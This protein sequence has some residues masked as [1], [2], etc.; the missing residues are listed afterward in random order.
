KI[1]NNMSHKAGE[2]ADLTLSAELIN[3]LLPK[4]KFYYRFNGSLTTPPCS[5]GVRW[6]VLQNYSTISSTQTKE[7]LDIFHHENSRPVQSIN[8]RKVM[9]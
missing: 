1:W 2:K 5:E 7:F 8:A 9:Q 4:D 6:L 3:S